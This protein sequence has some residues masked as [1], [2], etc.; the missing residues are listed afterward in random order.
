M[1]EGSLLKKI[2]E[3]LKKLKDR[4]N[5]SSTVTVVPSS[6]EKNV[7]SD[8]SLFVK[9]PL[10]SQPSSSLTSSASLSIAPP[11]FLSNN[12]RT[13][14]TRSEDEKGYYT[15]KER[16]RPSSSSASY[17]SESEE[18]NYQDAIDQ[19]SPR[20][21]GAV[22]KDLEGTERKE[23]FLS[24][25]MKESKE[26]SKVAKPAAAEIATKPVFVGKG[27]SPE[28][29]GFYSSSIGK[30]NDTLLQRTS[31]SSSVKE[32]KQEEPEDAKSQATASLGSLS[33]SPSKNNINR[34]LK[35]KEIPVVLP[36]SPI[37]SPL[38]AEKKSESPAFSKRSGNS[39]LNRIAAFEN[40]I[41]PSPPPSP[42]NKGT[43]SSKPSSSSASSSPVRQNTDNISNVSS[44]LFSPTKSSSVTP[45]RPV[46]PAPSFKRP[47][48]DPSSSSAEQDTSTDLMLSP[49]P[50]S[51]L[52]PSRGPETESKQVTPQPVTPPTKQQQLDNS[53]DE[54][55]DH[56][57]VSPLLS[58][59]QQQQPRE[60]KE[61]LFSPLTDV[62]EE[63][64]DRRKSQLQNLSS[65]FD[66]ED[67][68]EEDVMEGSNNEIHLNF[69]DEHSASV[70]LKEEGH[71][72]GSG[73]ET[74]RKSNNQEEEEENEDQEE[75]DEEDFV[76]SEESSVI[77]DHELEDVD[78]DEEED[79]ETASHHD[80][81]EGSNV[82]QHDSQGTMQNESNE[83]EPE[84]SPAFSGSN[85]ENPE[86]MSSPSPSPSS[87]QSPNPSSNRSNSSG[88]GIILSGSLLSRNKK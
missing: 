5:P 27:D 52:S 80:D 11:P 53:F 19:T 66:H 18:E 64:L 46:S 50:S 76:S 73:N 57:V 35:M 39:I 31:S 70:L 84:K 87:S 14:S 2:L 26:P 55:D 8:T 25:Q 28:K 61:S 4:P 41:Q 75:H 17:G 78:N 47:A 23:E 69:H 3:E 6:P 85:P 32:G 82:N 79:D 62:S 42:Y 67:D 30:V 45:V 44:P 34:E 60:R 59:Q 43:T 51:S 63:E 13:T 7:S 71:G 56:V 38:P 65:S 83:S 22:K 88:G 21:V 29:K 81:N 12:N 20:V 10:S 36:V 9:P 48:T 1:K 33:F 58:P 37:G 49:T 86:T 72:G 74:R 40:K 54:S 16:R 68:D 77:R 24:S 15:P